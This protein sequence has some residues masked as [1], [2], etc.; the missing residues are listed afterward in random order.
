MTTII[1]LAGLM[2]GAWAGVALMCA[3]AISKGNE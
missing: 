1:F 3:L 2:I